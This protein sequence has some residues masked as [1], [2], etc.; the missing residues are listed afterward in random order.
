MTQQWSG[1]AQ[2]YPPNAQQY[3]AG[4]YQHNAGAHYN[5]NA[6]QRNASLQSNSSS[7]YGSVPSQT[8][9]TVYHPNG[10][11]PPPNTAFSP[12][13]PSQQPG[14]MP[15]P[16][17]Q[18]NPN[19]NFPT[20]SSQQTHVPL[21]QPTNFQ[22]A[23]SRHNSAPSLSGTGHF[24]APLNDNDESLSSD[25]NFFS[26]EAD[27]LE[28]PYHGAECPYARSQDEIDPD[29]SLG[30]IVYRPALPTLRPLSA[31][32]REAELEAIAPRIPQPTDH[33]SISE[34]FINSR[35]ESNLLDV[36]QT[37]RWD[38]VRNDPVFRAFPAVSTAFISPAQMRANW[39]DRPD[40]N[41]AERVESP[42]PEPE[43]ALPSTTSQESDVLNNL[44]QALDNS[45]NSLDN[46]NTS[47]IDRP[48][49]LGGVVR[50]QAQEDILA[51]LGVTGPP[52][53]VYQT[54]GPAYSRNNSISGHQNGPR[55]SIAHPPPRPPP[56]PGRPPNG[57]HRSQSREEWSSKDWSAKDWADLTALHSRNRRSVSVSSDHTAAG[58]DFSSENVQII[59]E[60]AV[61]GRSGAEDP[62]RT[63]R[64]PLRAENRKR[65]FE[66]GDEDGAA[67]DSGSEN[68]TP[69]PG[70]KAARTS[71]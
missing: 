32:A 44:E 13:A 7:Q 23:Q 40:P 21:Q 56:P 28:T 9:G 47:A 45:S 14:P 59:T 43:P 41:W 11:M 37:D 61:N 39:R 65:T 18:Q 49:A 24:D 31:T 1:G 16:W 46:P 20:L 5:H 62:D 58:S 70:R 22:N 69:R 38:G 6:H 27:N 15:P 2:Q 30:E 36:R 26:E 19:N 55:G 10:S 57:R 66:G 33:E 29:L 60:L 4:G 71:K 54:P 8:N 3:N 63:P 52:K 34:Y 51:S 12:P 35:R 50:D 48:R 67:G 17:Q 42:T 53:T 64:A 25:L 68:S